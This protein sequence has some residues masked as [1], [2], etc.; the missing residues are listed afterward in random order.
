[1]TTALY[2]GPYARWSLGG[3]E[4]PPFSSPINYHY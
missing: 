2:A 1:M 3:S 4:E